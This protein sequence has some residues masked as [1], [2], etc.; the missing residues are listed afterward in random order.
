L[1]T[2]NFDP[3]K[4][5]LQSHQAYQQEQGNHGASSYSDNP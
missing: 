1:V 3:E 2:T 4:G 5:K